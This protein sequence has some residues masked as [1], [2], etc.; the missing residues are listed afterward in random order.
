METGRHRDRLGRPRAPGSST[1]IHKGEHCVC[2]THLGWTAWPSLPLCLEASSEIRSVRGL[3]Y[4]PL[5]KQV[6]R[7]NTSSWACVPLRREYTG[8]VGKTV[9]LPA[10]PWEQQPQKTPSRSLQQL[11]RRSKDN[12]LRS[13]AADLGLSGAAQKRVLRNDSA[14]PRLSPCLQPLCPWL[15]LVT[16][17]RGGPG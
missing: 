11:N 14:N 16:T 3:P 8:T 13:E 2:R 10:S 17:G 15:E 6:A 1:L 12:T 5:Y 4:L 7:V 9:Q